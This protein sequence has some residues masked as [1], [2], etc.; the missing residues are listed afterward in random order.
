MVWNSLMAACVLCPSPNRYAA[1][2]YTCRGYLYISYAC[3]PLLSH[4]ATGYNT[5]IFL[6]TCSLLCLG[7]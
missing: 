2:A 3:V 1:I 5:A 7:L 6:T 4:N